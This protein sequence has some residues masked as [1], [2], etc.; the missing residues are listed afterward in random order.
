[1]EAAEDVPDQRDPLALAVDQQDRLDQLAHRVQM[2]GQAQD[3]LAAT[4][5][6]NT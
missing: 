6:V 5:H 3:S 4:G 2:A 1:M